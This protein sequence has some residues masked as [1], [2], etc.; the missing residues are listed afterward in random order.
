MPVNDIKNI[1]IIYRNNKYRVMN[2]EVEFTRGELMKRFLTLAVAVLFVMMPLVSATARTVISDSDLD[3][4]TAEAG[5]SIEFTNLSVGNTSTLS[6]ISWGDPSGF[7]GY[8]TPGYFGFS[9][10]AISGNLARIGQTGVAGLSN[11]MVI[12]V[13]N[14]GNVTKIFIVLPTI[15]LG[16]AN[17]SGWMLAD[18]TANFSSPSFSEGGIL[19]LNGFSTQITGTVA[20]Y[21]H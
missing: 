17:I 15:T 2:E 6:S 10:I 12:D 11:T 8:T 19:S 13:G 5:V 4:I 9:N 20:I 7:T 3:T 18:R 1:G 14:S 16:T 21:G